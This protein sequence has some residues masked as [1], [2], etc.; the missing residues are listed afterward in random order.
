MLFLVST[1]GFAATYNNNLKGF[2]KYNL[3]YEDGSVTDSKYAPAINL[4]G[5]NYIAT[6]ELMKKRIIDKAMNY[7]NIMTLSLPKKANIPSANNQ[8]IEDITLLKDFRKKVEKFLFIEMATNDGEK[9]WN[10]NTAAVAMTILNQNKKDSTQSYIDLMNISGC[11]ENFKSDNETYLKILSF[12]PNELV[13]INEYINQMST[14]GILLSR[15][16]YTLPTDK[17]YNKIVK[18]R[19]DF[20]DLGLKILSDYTD[21]LSKVG[22]K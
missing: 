14:M 1:S 20:D 3:Y 18:A 12:S 17:D 11:V 19:K 7:D 15:N 10:T 21:S 13:I 2:I 22:F 6:S 9:I 8:N 5:K 16:V 4:N